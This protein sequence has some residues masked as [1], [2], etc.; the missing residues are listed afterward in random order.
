[1]TRHL[2][3]IVAAATAL[4]TPALA[5][6]DTQWFEAEN[7]AGAITS[8]LL[9]KNDSAASAGSYIVGPDGLNSQNTPPAT[10]TAKYSFGVSAPGT[11][12]I[13][14]RVKA[15][16]TTSNSFWVRMDNGPWI[17]WS[18]I[19]LGSAWHWDFVHDNV[20][21]TSP[22]LFNLAAGNHVFEVAYR[23]NR[24][25]L[26]LLVITDDPTFSPT[27]ALSPPEE[28]RDVRALSGIGTIRFTW[29][30][31]RGAQSYA[32]ERRNGYVGSYVPYATTTGHVFTDSVP[33]DEVF[34]YK[35][36]SVRGERRTPIPYDYC[37]QATN[38]ISMV[39][40]ASQGNATPP[41]IFDGTFI[42]PAAGANSTA[43]PP[44][45]GYARYDFQLASA[46]TV[47]VWAIV[48]A[49]NGNDDSF[50]VRVDNGAWINWNGIRGQGFYS[51]DDVHDFN[52]GS[53]PVHFSLP[54][55]SH[56][57]EFAYREDGTAIKR[58]WV[59]SNLSTTPP[60]GAFD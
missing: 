51:W 2:A 17:R 13:F 23:E 5:S 40:E 3:V 14:A 19:V 34:C 55:G 8:P 41:M 1:M 22:I 57:L 37:W 53:R 36:I 47:K 39:F 10:G 46:A 52:N 35:I 16:D 25:Q 30:L 6:A 44:S 49:P 15:F 4:L 42:R 9:I 26:D 59:T 43:A 18:D 33:I 32:I 48:D 21:P 56:K 50:W 7:V 29:T 28:P 58:I 60:P 38:S 20:S 11:Y 54:A 12:R 31:A 45:T 27:A 24:T